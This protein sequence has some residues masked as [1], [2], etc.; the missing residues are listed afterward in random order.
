L[1]SAVGSNREAEEISGFAL[2]CDQDEPVELSLDFRSFGNVTPLEHQVM[3]GSDLTAVNSF[4]DPEKVKP[5]TVA[6]PGQSGNMISVI[7]PKLSWNMLRF[8]AK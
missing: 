4:N 7:L 3:D 8:S 6:I 2:N 1:Q 5:H